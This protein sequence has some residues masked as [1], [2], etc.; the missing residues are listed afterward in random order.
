MTIFTPGYIAKPPCNH[1]PHC[2]VSKY[3]ANKRR[4]RRTYRRVSRTCFS[5]LAYNISFTD[6]NYTY[7]IYNVAHAILTFSQC[8]FLILLQTTSVGG[9]SVVEKLSFY[10]HTECECRERS[11]YDTTNE[12]PADQRVYR[13]QSSPPPQN[14]KKSPARKP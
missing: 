3:L 11:E 1:F 2:G 5:T 10:N 13:H 9:A 7:R 6:I 8:L 14:M 12:K 4:Y